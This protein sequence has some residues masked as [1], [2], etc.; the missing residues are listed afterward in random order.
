MR[1]FSR[2]I[3]CSAARQALRLI[4]ENDHHRRGTPAALLG[5]ATWAS[6]EL[7]AAFTAFSQAMGSYQQAGNTLYAITGT[8]ILADI[9]LAQGQLPQAFHI[10]EQALQLAH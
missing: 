1:Q 2:N 4:P 10:Y 8:F 6:G 5:L 9:R 7:T 3:G